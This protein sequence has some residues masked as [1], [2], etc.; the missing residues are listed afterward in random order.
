MT[1]SRCVDII[2]PTYQEVQNI[3]RLLECLGSVRSSS[4]LDLRVL[5]MDDDS[6]DGSHELVLSLGLPW[7]KL[8]TREA[9]RGLSAAVLDG[10]ARARCDLV[11]VMDADL[12]HPPEK[13]PDCGAGCRRRYRRGLALYRRRFHGR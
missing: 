10:I 1:Q 3:P 11:V 2:V 8:V 7:V 13:I 5:F 12:S 4:G 6:R 9:D